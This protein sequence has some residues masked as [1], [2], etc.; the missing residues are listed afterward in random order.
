MPHKLA[1]LL[2]QQSAPPAKIE[3]GW[4]SHEHVLSRQG[5]VHMALRSEIP[6]RIPVAF[7][8]CT[9]GL[10]GRRGATGKN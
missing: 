9:N 7:R 10:P 6:A 1:A 2:S 3:Y 5:C 4:N 8:L